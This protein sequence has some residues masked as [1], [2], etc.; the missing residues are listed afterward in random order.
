[1]PIPQRGCAPQVEAKLAE[2]GVSTVCVSAGCPN[3]A[4]CF[5][6]GEATF[7]LL[8]QGCSRNC[9]FCAMGEEAVTPVDATEP[10]RVAQTVASLEL[11]YVVLTSVTRDDLP[12]GGAAHIC[13]TAREIRAHAPHTRVEALLPDFGG[14]R[15]ALFLAATGSFSIVGHNVEMVP[16]LYTRYRSGGGFQ[17]SLSVLHALGEHGIPTK[18]GFMVGLGET[19]EEVL[20]LIS[21]LSDT[22]ISVLTAGQYLPGRRGGITPKR[23]VSPEEFEIYAAHAQECGIASVR[24]GPYVRSSLNAADC[25]REICK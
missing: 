3:R 16:S 19:Q 20:S 4:H 25:F 22:G 8:G 17:R 1:M 18:S 15:R 5:S 2:Q 9:L 7:L 14:C 6:Q 10:Q 11:S 24:M 21:T 13:Q 23:Y 12:D